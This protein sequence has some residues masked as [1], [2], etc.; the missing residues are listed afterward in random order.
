MVFWIHS[1]KAS[2]RSRSCLLLPSVREQVQRRYAARALRLISGGSPRYAAQKSL[3]VD[4]FAKRL[5][6]SRSDIAANAI[7]NTL[8]P[9]TRQGITRD[10]FIRR[11]DLAELEVSAPSQKFLALAQQKRLHLIGERRRERGHRQTNMISE[12]ASSA[13]PVHRLV[14]CI[15]S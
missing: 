7:E 15:Y 9:A 12:P 4:D 5:C 2:L 10:L 3:V 14:L 11:I 8:H 1:S 6:P 13:T